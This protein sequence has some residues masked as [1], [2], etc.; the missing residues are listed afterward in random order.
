MLCLFVSLDGVYQPVVLAEKSD[1]KLAE[2]FN[3]Y[4]PQGYIYSYTDRMI[5]FYGANYYLND[6]MRNFTLE[7]PKAKAMWPCRSKTRNPS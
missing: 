4:V 7:I 2:C 1:K 5:R 3:Q 6:R